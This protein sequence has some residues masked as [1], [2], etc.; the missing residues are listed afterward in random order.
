MTPAPAA[1]HL[2]GSGTHASKTKARGKTG[3]LLALARQ[4]ARDPGK[5]AAKSGVAGVFSRILASKAAPQAAPLDTALIALQNAVR[6]LAAL[7]LSQALRLEKVLGQ[8]LEDARLTL[9]QKAARIK[10]LAGE[11]QELLAALGIGE[12]ERASQARPR[13]VAGTEP[14][15]SSAVLPVRQESARRA[16]EPRV[17]VL[18]LRKKAE[19][20]GGEAQGL[21]ARPQAV[22]APEGAPVGVP[23]A[24]RPAM[25]RDSRVR[26]AHA[27]QVP[28]P[29]TPLERLRELAGAELTRAAGIILRDG[30]G[31]IRLVLKPESLGSVRV[32]LNLTD[33]GIDGK[34][35][36]DNPAVKHLMEQSIDSLTRALSADGFQTASLQVSVG[37]RGGGAATEDREIPV[38]L[39]IESERGFGGMVP[40]AEADWGDLLVNLFA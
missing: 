4:S 19:D 33:N 39:R 21:P 40:D 13:A 1:L 26:A 3:V 30:G 22:A 12:H 5:A 32:R 29:Q 8:I 34:I 20:K 15:D 23:G 14:R 7:D 28:V 9:R 11:A 37:G 25:E 18:D 10:A 6:L 31:E 16:Q 35:I 36:V 38:A 24:V 27:P 2:E 17:F